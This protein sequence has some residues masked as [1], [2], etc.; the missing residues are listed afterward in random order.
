MTPHMKTQLHVLLAL[1]G[2]AGAAFA[3]PETFDFKDPKGVNNAVF[4]LDAPLEAVT[5]NAIGISGKVTFDPAA[6]G[7]TRGKIVVAS[8]SMHVANPMQL[9]HL[10]SDKWMDVA[11]Y[12]EISFEAKDLKN[13]KTN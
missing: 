10:R 9:E 1:A 7:A 5:G 4:K 12:P 3:A 2:F 13:V 8:T 6:P 11:K